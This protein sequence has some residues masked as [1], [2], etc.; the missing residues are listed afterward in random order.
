MEH[1][2]LKLL[3]RFLTRLRLDSAALSPEQVSLLP[4]SLLYLIT[5]NHMPLRSEACFQAL[6]KHL[7][8]LRADGYLKKFAPLP[9]PP[10]YLSPHLT[11]LHLERVVIQNPEEW[12]AHVPANL[13]SLYVRYK[14][15]ISA[16]VVSALPCHRSLV[17]LYLHFSIMPQD[18]FVEILKVLPRRRLLGMSLSCKCK[19]TSPGCGMTNEDLQH[20]PPGLC[21]AGLPHAPL[22]D[23]GGL[24][25]APPCLTYF[26]AGDNSFHVV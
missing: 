12:F 17:Q 11:S 6:P 1:P 5:E 18:A 23:K 20:L 9:S 22:I 2:V 8:E 24:K 26:Y 25:F 16:R 4:A 3:P 21:S 10:T 7:I 14:G 13:T 15:T 19:K